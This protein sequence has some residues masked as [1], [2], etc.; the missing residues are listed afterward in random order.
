[1]LE[2]LKA[3]AVTFGVALLATVIGGIGVVHYAEWLITAPKDEAA[4][5]VLTK[6]IENNQKIFKKVHSENQQ[7]TKD[8]HEKDRKKQEELAE[9]EKQARLAQEERERKAEL[10]REKR[11]KEEREQRARLEEKKKHVAELR[12]AIDAFAAAMVKLDTYN[13]AVAESYKSEGKR[14]AFMLSHSPKTLETMHPVLMKKFNS[15]RMLVDSD[16]VADFELYNF[17]DEVRVAAFKDTVRLDNE[18][19]A[20]YSKH[21]NPSFFKEVGKRLKA[22]EKER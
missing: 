11:A 6:E 16:S 2:F 22:I 5:V 18:K 4:Q 20:V 17:I 21:I 19:S 8:E 15:I 1:M 9:Q 7:V 12:N 3:H 10:E 14:W 13:I